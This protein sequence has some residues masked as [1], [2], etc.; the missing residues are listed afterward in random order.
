MTRSTLLLASLMLVACR[1]PAADPQTSAGQAATA[2]APVFE[3]SAGA[4]ATAEAPTKAK[5]EVDEGLTADDDNGPEGAEASADA[6]VAGEQADE[7]DV[8][9]EAPVEALPEVDVRNVGMHI[10]GEKNTA[11][12][13]RPIRAVVQAHYDAMK[14]CWGKAT[15]P[16]HKAT[17]GIDMRIPGEGGKVTVKKPRSGLEGEARQCLVDLFASIEFP[18]QPGKRPRMVSFSVEFTKKK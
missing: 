7:A 3:R 14:Q 12:Q 4:P 16:P 17:F 2:S 13:K 6:E 1:E 10:G 18:P 15:E 5:T 11:A 9:T 8:A